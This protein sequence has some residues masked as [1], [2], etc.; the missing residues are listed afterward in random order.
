MTDRMTDL[1]I[2]ILRFCLEDGAKQTG[3]ILAVPALRAYPRRLV[4]R[5]I[6]ALALAGLLETWGRTSGAWYLTSHLGFVV[7]ATLRETET[8]SSKCRHNAADD[9]D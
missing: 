9:V 4:R 3:D 6:H 2:P 7:L 1:R 5:T 8:L